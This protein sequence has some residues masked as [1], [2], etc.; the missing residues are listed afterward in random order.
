MIW[1]IIHVRSE[2]ISFH[3]VTQSL[4][5]KRDWCQSSSYQCETRKHITGR[6]RW[7]REGICFC[8]LYWSFIMEIGPAGKSPQMPPRMIPLITRPRLESCRQA[9]Q[10]GLN[11]V[12][13]S[14]P[15]PFRLL[16][17]QL[18]ERGSMHDTSRGVRVCK[19]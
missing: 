17:R 6:Q 5:R 9:G 14:Y 18:M 19:K 8:Q 4:P 3:E 15:I 10:A 1:V 16:N 2:Q 13:Y 11:N 7:L 12:C